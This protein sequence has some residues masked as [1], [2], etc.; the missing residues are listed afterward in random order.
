M[1]PSWPD[2]LFPIQWADLPGC[3]MG[4][5]GSIFRRGRVVALMFLSRTPTA[6]LLSLSLL[7]AVAL[8]CLESRRQSYV[9]GF[10]T[11]AAHFQCVASDRTGLTFVFSG[12]PFG[13]EYALSAD[14]YVLPAINARSVH[15]EIYDKSLEK[16]KLLGIHLSAGTWSLTQLQTAG[17][18]ALL[19]PYWLLFV[20]LAILPVRA[21]RRQCVRISRGR[22]G[23]CLECGYD[24]R[25]SKERCSECGV[26]IGKSRIWARTDRTRAVSNLAW[27]LAILLIV[28]ISSILFWRDRRAQ[29]MTIPGLAD[30]GII[31][32]LPQDDGQ[33]FVRVYP[34]DDIVWQAGLPAGQGGDELFNQVISSVAV[35]DSWSDNGGSIGWALADR[36]R[37]I[38]KQ[39]ERGHAELCNLLHVLRSSDEQAG[40]AAAY[41]AQVARLDAII[42]E[43]DLKDVQ[44]DK[45]LAGIAKSANCSV[46]VNWQ[47]LEGLDVSQQNRLSMHLWNVTARDAIT[48]ALLNAA[49][50]KP[51]G[52]APDFGG[53]IVEGYEILDHF[54]WKVAVYDVSDLVRQKLDYATSHPPPPP[55]PP[56][57]PAVTNAPFAGGRFENRWPPTTSEAIQDIVDLIEKTVAEDSWLDNGGGTGRIRFFGQGLIIGQTDAVHAEIRDLLSSLRRGENRKLPV[58][59]AH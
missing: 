25:H 49:G 29:G 48:A 33:T 36:A 53:C 47:D 6:S 20:L 38:V 15:D 2:Y 11:P 21:I 27:I 7:I 57:W 24:L 31:Q 54:G 13:P 17:F 18:A 32:N 40:Q 37:L 12:I 9:L 1:R 34:V 5:A 19:V 28:S 56:R 39:N 16:W 42:P 55:L 46:V 41:A 8:L 26:A 44:V 51:V 59:T 35:S 4:L 52:A 3:V 10:V 45:A 43:I 14:M 58:P 50:D 22:R 30:V 23:R